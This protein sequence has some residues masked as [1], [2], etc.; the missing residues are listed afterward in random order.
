M[1]TVRNFYAVKM[2]TS[3]ILIHLRRL[4]VHFTSDEKLA[5]LYFILLVEITVAGHGIYRA[6]KRTGQYCVC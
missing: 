6:G 2:M 5:L 1:S 4:T 3:P